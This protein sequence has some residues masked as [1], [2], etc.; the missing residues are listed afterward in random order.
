MQAR[1]TTSITATTDTR[2]AARSS[3]AG[4]RGASF[5]Q[6]E[7]LGGQVNSI[8]QDPFHED[9]LFAETLAPAS[10]GA[11]T[12]GTDWQRPT[13]SMPSPLWSLVA[14]PARPGRLYAG[15]EQGVFRTVDGGH[16]WEA[17]S[18]G[19]TSTYVSTLRISPD[20]SRLHAGT[21]GG[22]VF[23]LDLR[24][25]SAFPCVPSAARL[26][27]VGNR[28]ALDLVAARRGESRYDPG[29][30]HPLNDRAGYFGL[31]TATGDPD[32]PEII[33]KRSARGRSGN[34][35]R[36]SSTPA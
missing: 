15:T 25:A 2:R 17:F 32:L 5:T 20:G 6:S 22:G 34:P 36:P 8:A 4:D 26:C 27:L 35:A 16:T 23:D 31:P 28:Y 18:A 11:S 9:V 13:S 14:D 24:E 19:L 3:S 12:A 30:A 1:T 29:A 10:P 33:V 7:D 21:A